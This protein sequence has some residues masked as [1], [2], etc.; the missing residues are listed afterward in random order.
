MTKC[1]IRP[2]VKNKVIENNQ[3]NIKDTS[4]T[5]RKR[6]KTLNPFGDVGIVAN[7]LQGPCVMKYSYVLLLEGIFSASD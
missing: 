2:Q 1:F 6:E 4:G 7:E 5:N 3:T